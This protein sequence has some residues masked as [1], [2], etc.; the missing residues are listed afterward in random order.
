MSKA[1]AMSSRL[2]SSSALFMTCIH[3]Q[4]PLACALTPCC[5]TADFNHI[6]CL[7]V[8]IMQDHHD[9]LQCWPRTPVVSV[10]FYQGRNACCR[11]K[12]V[13]V[14]Q[15]KALPDTSSVSGSAWATK[16]PWN[17]ACSK[18]ACPQSGPGC[19]RYQDK[20]TQEW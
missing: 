14:L 12:T 16:S 1:M 5:N 11:I 13:G 7:F 19:H 6:F 3:T 9:V 17:A 20:Q 15:R 2:F 10:Q 18:T 8:W 4:Q